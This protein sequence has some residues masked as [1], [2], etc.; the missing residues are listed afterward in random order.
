MKGCIPRGMNKSSQG[1]VN[2][3]RKLLEVG[4]SCQVYL[5]K[6]NLALHL[7]TKGSFVF[8]FYYSDDLTKR[9][10]YWNVSNCKRKNIFRRR[11][12]RQK[13]GD[14]AGK[15]PST[16]QRSNFTPFYLRLESRQDKSHPD[17]NITYI[18]WQIL[19]KRVKFPFGYK[20]VANNSLLHINPVVGLGRLSGEKYCSTEIVITLKMTRPVKIIRFKKT[21]ILAK[22]HWWKQSQTLYTF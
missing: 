21:F 13:S 3:A 20:N 22:R 4:G 7:Q 11:R 19:Q 2:L 15:L 17:I 16:S 1:L 14:K 5:V 6:A 10:F 8:H 12:G 18:K 9:Q